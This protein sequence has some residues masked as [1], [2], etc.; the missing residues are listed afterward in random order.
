MRARSRCTKRLHNP[1][2][3]TARRMRYAADLMSP[4]FDS[5]RE[6]LSL[7]LLQ[8]GVTTFLGSMFVFSA[9]HSGRD[10]EQTLDV[11]ESSL[12]TMRDEGA[13]PPEITSNQRW[14]CSGLFPRSDYAERRL[15]AGLTVVSP[16]Q[17][18]I[19]AP[20]TRDPN[21]LSS[22]MMPTGTAPQQV[23]SPHR[24]LCLPPRAD[25]PLSR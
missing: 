18:I 12:G 4:K 6:R 19:N 9:T 15:H 21:S 10:V 23:H 16:G 17:T 22:W 1:S 5:L 7:H 11:L 8:R 25:W 13:M 3:Q 24:N 20:R 14:Q 2:P